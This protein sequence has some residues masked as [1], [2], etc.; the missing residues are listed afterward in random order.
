MLFSSIVPKEYL[1]RIDKTKKK[2]EQRNID[3]LV[4]YSDSWRNANC[5]YLSGIKPYVM[6]TRA[7]YDYAPMAVMTIPLDEDPTIY[8]PLAVWAK[9]DL[10]GTLREKPFI[11]VKNLSHVKEGI[12][13]A[14]MKSKW[15]GFEGK[16]ITPWQVYEDLTKAAGKQMEDVLIL[17]EMRKVKS[18]SEIKLMEIASN[19]NDRI[20]ED[21]VNGIIRYGVTEKEVAREIE[22]IGH[23]L[24]AEYVDA[25]YMIGRHIDFGHPTD[26]TPIDGDILSLH[27]ILAYEGYYSDNDRIFGFG[28]LT[29]RERNLATLAKDAFY[30]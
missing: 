6:P 8:I 16:D 9:R 19:I 27:V 23:S 25:Q 18:D 3:L 29:E 24:G 15:I 26:T 12:E 21:L 7:Y 10:A 17:E 22:S 30:N 1:E 13:K 2:M 4:V 20:C 14:A 5:R 11:N 28:K